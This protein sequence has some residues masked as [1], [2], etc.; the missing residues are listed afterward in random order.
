MQLVR[1]ALAFFLI[2][3]PAMGQQTPAAQAFR[4]TYLTASTAYID[5]GR[6]DGLR[7]G[8]SVRVVHGG[9]PAALLRV[10]YLASHQAACD[11][12]SPSVAVAVGDTVTFHPAALPQPDTLADTPAR[13]RVPGVA[14]AGTSRRRYRSSRLR[15]RI[16]A[17]YLSVWQG[18]SAGGG[19]W[20]Q[21][22]LDIRLDGQSLGGAPIGLVLDIRTRR[23][24][25]SRADGSRVSDGRTRVYQAAIQVN[26]PGSPFRLSAGR[27]FSPTLSSISLFDGAM[28][29]FNQ[30]GW[31]MGVFAGSEPEPIEFGYSGAV[32]DYGAY[33]QLHSRP[34]SK[35][36]WSMTLGGIGSYAQRITNREF[37]YL[38]VAWTSRRLSLYG[39]QEIDY[40]RPW[41]Q[42]IGEHPVS[43]TSTYASLRYEAAKGL[44]FSTGFDNRRNVRL[45]RDAVTPETAFDDSFR[46][47]IWG[48]LSLQMGGRG[49]VAFD[50]RTNGGGSAGRASAYTLSL[51]I[52][53]LTRLAVSARSRTTRYLGPRE[54]GWLQSLAVG[55]APIPSLHIELNGGIR[56][57]QDPLAVPDNVRVVW[58]GADAD[59][60]L[61]RAWYL[62]GSA[63]REVGGFETNN[64]L[65][66][67]L[68]YR[69]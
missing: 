69:F 28:A 58:I 39:T 42:L 11:L 17:R 33:V 34:E 46:Q 50:A 64:Q 24:S 65:Y 1:V 59:L 48:G 52:D 41:K 3:T 37:V 9:E 30:A 23:T 19:R 29:D 62:I 5:A 60:N 21:P 53:R 12:V 35:D 18:G 7:E 31:G 67:G 36:R 8:D 68:S 44:S 16:G 57:G 20:S 26:P 63:T 49:R 4:I 54:S 61:A 2:A 40:Y 55:G 6:D 51:G 32:R 66:G 43:P 27:Q 15:G 22:A 13:R 14:A 47:G 56:V 45:Y 25:T 38:Q 10:S